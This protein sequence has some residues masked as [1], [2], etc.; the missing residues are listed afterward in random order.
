MHADN[1]LRVRAHQYQ[2]LL[3][4]H[5]L[6]YFLPHGDKLRLIGNP[7]KKTARLLLLTHNPELIKCLPGPRPSSLVADVINKIHH[8]RIRSSSYKQPLSSPQKEKLE[9]ANQVISSLTS[10]LKLERALSISDYEEQEQ[11]RL[12]VLTLI[13]TA[14]NSN[15][16]I[17][18]DPVTSQGQLG[19]ILA[20][21][22]KTAQNY[23]FNRVHP[24]SY[25]DQLD[26]N[27]FKLK[28]DSWIVWDSEVH[29]G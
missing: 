1:H 15:R 8:Y 29:L 17:A 28:P 10:L 2:Y 21:A 18:D 5:D 14:R 22:Y 23:Y 27:P 24:T 16:L 25:E 19:I 4:G 3:Q 7:D 9:L 20:N 12:Q 11:L 26:F 6:E 13:D